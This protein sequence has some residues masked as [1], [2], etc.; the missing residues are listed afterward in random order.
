MYA[1]R[2]TP[3][4]MAAIGETQRRRK[5]QDAYNK[6]HGIEP[7]TVIKAVRDLVSGGE[8]EDAPRDFDFTAKQ[9]TGAER[10]QVIARLE[11]EM[12][13]AAKLLEFEYA[14]RL[15]DQIIQLQG[16]QG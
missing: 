13:E 14:A 1:D 2:M 6:E 10:A 15:R 8:T 4:M 12:R 16:K 3:S 7:K 11:K 9:M 5:L